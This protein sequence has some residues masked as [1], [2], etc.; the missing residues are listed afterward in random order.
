M[1]KPEFSNHTVK[2]VAESLK[3]MLDLRN[4]YN[5]DNL[6]LY[7]VLLRL[8]KIMAGMQIFARNFVI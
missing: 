4:V 7:R 6:D 3:M 2:I 5:Q 1:F 8:H